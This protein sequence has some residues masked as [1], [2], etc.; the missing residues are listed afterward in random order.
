MQADD[1]DFVADLAVAALDTAGGHGAAALDREDVL[2][3]HEERLVLFAD[4]VRNVGVEGVHQLVDALAGLVVLAVGVKGGLGAAA[5][6]RDLVAGELVLGEQLA[7]LQLDE[8][9]Q[10]G[11]VDGVDLVQEDDDTGHADLTGQQDVLA[12][13]R[14]G[15]VVGGDDEDGAVH[16]GGA[17]DHVLDVVGVAGAID[18]GV[19]PVRRFVLDVG[20]GDGHRLVLVAHDA[21][22][23]DFGV[24]L[25]LFQLVLERLAGQNRR[26]QG[27]L[28][29]VDVA[30]GAHVDVR[31]GPLKDVLSHH[32]S[33]KTSSGPSKG[34]S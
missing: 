26:G 16:L 9:E 34:W 3:G 21:A 31:F 19:V 6:D 2:D 18:V 33:E 4:G 20:D 29:V 10:L 27:G 12:R 7:K 23:G 8:V 13:L 32:S 1:L 30:D 11:I 22:L 14:H 24:G 28:A 17:G 5:D 25:E 15:A